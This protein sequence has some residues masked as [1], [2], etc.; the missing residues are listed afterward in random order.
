MTGDELRAIRKG[1]KLSQENMAR[2]IGMSVSSIRA[3]EQDINRISAVTET[4]ILTL[5][6]KMESDK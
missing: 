5:K 4:A 6:E 1:L 2:M 3:W